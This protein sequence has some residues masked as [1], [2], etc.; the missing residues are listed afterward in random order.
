ML[1]LPF[2]AILMIATIGH[3]SGEETIPIPMLADFSRDILRPV[4]EF[5][6]KNRKQIAKY[7]NRKQIAQYTNSQT[8]I[9]VPCESVKK[10]NE[11]FKHFLKKVMEL[12]GKPGSNDGDSVSQL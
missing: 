1:L 3:V 11:K 9:S 4:E 7:E 8:S 6:D 2:L 12:I 10:L 5:C